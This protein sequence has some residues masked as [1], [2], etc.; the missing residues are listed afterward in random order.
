MLRVLLR[1]GYVRGLFG[2]STIAVL[3]LLVTIVVVALSAPYLNRKR[4]PA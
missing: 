2:L 3:G 4:V 1:A